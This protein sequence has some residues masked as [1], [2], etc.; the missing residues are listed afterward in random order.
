MVQTQN[1]ALPVRGPGG[2]A[3]RKQHNQAPPECSRAALSFNLGPLALQNLMQCGGRGYS[4]P[5]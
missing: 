4:V 1:P 5:A 3:F 2:P